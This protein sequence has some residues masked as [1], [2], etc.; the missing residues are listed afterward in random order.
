MK[1]CSVCK[2]SWDDDFRMCPIDGAPLQEAAPGQVGDPYI[3]KSIAQCRL[4]E[5]AGEGDLG[6]I[7]KAEEPIRGVVAIQLIGPERIASPILLEAFGDTVKGVSKLNHPN[8]VRVYGLE[9]A[10]DGTVAV[11]MEYIQGMTLQNY[12]RK[13]PGIDIVECCKL[14]RQA[15]EGVMAAHRLSIMHGAL[16]PS[17]IF[18]TAD[19]NIKVSGFHR[20]GLREG[21]DVFT[22]TPETL[23]YL[24]PEQVGIVRDLPAPDYRADVYALGV[25]LYELLAGRLPYEAKNPQELAAVMEGSP[26]LPPNFA[27][28]H[29]PPLL[30]RVVLKAV[31]KE[32]P[33]RHGSIEEFIRDLDAAKQP[34]REPA[35][36][37]ADY[38][39]EPQY[40]PPS[41]DSSLFGP[42][43]TSH[44]ESVENIWPEAAQAKESSGEG[45]VFSWFKTRAG[46]SRGSSRRT[47]RPAMDDSSYAPRSSSS[48]RRGEDDTAEHTVVVSGSG[49]GRTKRRSISDSFWG[50]SS[51]NMDYTGTGALPSRSFSNKVYIYLA[52][53]ALAVLV[54]LIVLVVWL[55]TPAMGRLNVT[56]IPPGAQVFLGEDPFGTTPTGFRDVKPG[57]YR[58]RL[59]LEGYETYVAEEEIS[60]NGKL[61][62]TYTLMKQSPLQLP[63]ML[64]P[65]D[66]T[67]ITSVPQTGSPAGTQNRT[68]QFQAAFNTALRARNLFPPSPDNAAETLRLWAQNE[69]GS[70]SPAF[71]QARQS[72]CQEVEAVGQ[73]KLAQKD[74]AGVRAILEQVRRYNPGTGCAV[75][76]A[77]S[78]DKAVSNSI[79][80]LRLSAQ[81]Q[82]NNQNYVT[83]ELQNALKYARLILGIDPGD[84]EA[85]AL[86]ADIFTRAWDQAQAKA[87]GRQHQ[88]A[89]DIYTAL[90]R[91]Y[92]NPPIAAAKIDD[93]IERQKLKVKQAEALRTPYSIQ[94][95]H[96]HG[97]KYVI[98][99]ARDCTGILRVDGFN[100]AYQGVEHSFKLSYDHLGAVKPDKTKITIQGTGIPE[101]KIDL[102]QVEK[103]PTPSMAEIA[104]RIQEYRRLYAEY[105]K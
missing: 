41:A 10:P 103:N 69:A 43:S 63:P 31:A 20:S 52:I 47:N 32:P 67:S 54:L 11:L 26:P 34:M 71:D 74:F 21:C 27:N 14:T 53:G 7:Y 24:A 101:G 2:R 92:P 95:R 13:H 77:Q 61:V 8:T 65:T 72:F 17:R 12:R 36:P 45:S 38:R 25:I 19:G 93:A 102:E 3:G 35:R 4:V 97:R 79:G 9:T 80:D 49:R 37:M 56:S 88:E 62:A 100:I 96:Y 91:N 73:E 76:L 29:V 64:T 15:A 1:I 5:K 59:Q 40:P 57:N 84:A 78:Y 42:P 94:V 48:R 89:L 81:A 68:P 75:G 51:S 104:N 6:P 82:M 23:P 105:I 22:A 70:P 90:K 55:R 83:P 87:A 18:V 99:G 28:P 66:T 86:D 85:K 60:E 44:K 33:D 98:F 46:S 58:I 50:S 16:H 30:S 39:Y